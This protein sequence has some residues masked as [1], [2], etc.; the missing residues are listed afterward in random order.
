MYE[1]S[2]LL[3]NDSLWVIGTN[4]DGQ[5]G[6]G[7]TN[8]ISKWTLS[9]TGVQTVSPGFYQT[10]VLKKDGSVWAAGGNEAGELGDG[11][12]TA[13]LTWK[14]V[15]TGV[16]AISARYQ[17]SFFIKADHS[18]W[19]VANQQDWATVHGQGLHKFA[20]NVESV[21]T[22]D[23]AVLF[24]KTDHTL[25]GLGHNTD[26]EF[27]NAFTAD[28]ETD[29]PV[30]LMS[31]VSAAAIS[32]YYSLVLKTDGTLWASGDDEIGQLGEP[33]DASLP[34]TYTMVLS[35]VSAIAAGYATSMAIKNDGTLWVAGDNSQATL[36]DGLGGPGGSEQES[37]AFKQVLTDVLA[38][39][40]EDRTLLVVKTDYTLWGAGDNTR[41]NMGIDPH[42]TPY[43][44]S[45]EKLAVP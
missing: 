28:T 25:W 18:L 3:R 17:M 31:G 33:F 8:D 16:L 36:G 22:G 6:L 11:T 21:A 29:T 43:V 27:G 1:Q 19:G 9:L 15:M 20:D 5:F 40:V 37:Y 13:S 34:H 35:D 41:E 12:A 32:G 10:L 38:G 39:A 2:Y 42:T 14:K 7:N 45:F 30:A 23:D 4:P 26:F 24:I 44:L